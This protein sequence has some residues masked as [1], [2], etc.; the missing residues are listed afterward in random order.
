MGYYRAYTYTTV[1]ATLSSINGYVSKTEGSKMFRM[2]SQGL[3]S[4]GLVRSDPS[5]LIRID[6]DHYQRIMHRRD[7]MARYPEH[8]LAARPRSIHA[9]HEIHEWLMTQYLPTRYPT[10]FQ[11]RKDRLYCTITDELIPTTVN[12][13]CKSNTEAAT[14]ALRTLSSLIDLDILILLPS[15]TATG[16]K[17]HLEA[18]AVCFPS[19]FNTRQ[20]LGLPLAAIH[21][22][23]T[24]YSEKLEKSMDRYFER[25]EVGKWVQRANWTITTHDK[26]FMPGDEGES[27]HL[28]P[29]EEI[30]TSK[31]E[32]NLEKC[33]LRIEDQKLFRM[34]KSKAIVFAFKTYLT[35]LW[36]LKE[37]EGREMAGAL[38]EAIEGMR[39]GNVPEVWLYKRGFEWSDKVVEYLR[40]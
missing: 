24:R 37:K 7:L 26:L 11:F 10:I 21:E 27:N 19:G 36:E 12:G 13:N 5:N 4:V 9:V 3:T 34:P 29:G 16:P 38:A 20:K 40:S 30:P 18:F 8:I 1:Q 23:V 17:Y 6:R 25:L 32:I 14:A 22:P 39:K 28:R 31:K 15:P 2:L 33:H 35:P